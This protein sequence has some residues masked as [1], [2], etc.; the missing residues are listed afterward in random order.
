MNNNI[1]SPL[2]QSNEGFVIKTTTDL[3][4][5]KESKNNTLAEKNIAL[6]QTETVDLTEKVI[7]SQ[8]VTEQNKTVVSEQE[9]N[10]ALEIVSN[11]MHNSNK[12]V[13]FSKDNSSG[14]TVIIITDKET[15]EVIN[16]FPS[17]KIISM[18]KRIQNLNMEAESISGLLIDS[19]V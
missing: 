7:E 3:E 13:E 19:R 12:Q 14:R 15:Q 4:S 11:F 8:K 17:E 16:Q 9:I 10:H 1:N 5:T 6:T 18:A 2:S